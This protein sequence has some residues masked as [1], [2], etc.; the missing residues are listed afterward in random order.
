M[1]INPINFIDLIN[2][3]QERVN[4]HAVKKF[5]AMF[6]EDATFEIV[7]ISKFAGK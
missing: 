5:M 2:T 1:Y 4:Q 3:F 7:G 6:K